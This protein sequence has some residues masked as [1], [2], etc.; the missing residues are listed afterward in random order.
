MS[1]CEWK[2]KPLFTTSLKLFAMSQEEYFIQFC[3]TCRSIV[4]TKH[5]YVCAQCGRPTCKFCGY[6]QKRDGR[7]CETCYNALPEDQKHA[8][9]Q[10]PTGALT[11]KRAF[12]VLALGIVVLILVLQPLGD[13]LIALF[14]GTFNSY[15]FSYALPAII[16]VII[17]VILVKLAPKPKSK[18]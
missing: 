4:I 7:I 15:A 18:G 3:K 2:F 12:A 11:R 6:K 16:L 5:M 9:A 13:F 1:F 8:F 17:G 14:T 10:A